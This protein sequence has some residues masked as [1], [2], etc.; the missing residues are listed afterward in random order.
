MEG[1]AMTVMALMM[2]NKLISLAR[3]ECVTTD[4]QTDGPIVMVRLMA[5][6]VVS[7]ND[8]MLSLHYLSNLPSRK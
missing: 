1:A 2:Q 6:V 8:F 7:K 5:S 4:G 3:K